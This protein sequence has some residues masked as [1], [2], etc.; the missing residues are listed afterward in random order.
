MA[1]LVR[2]ITS[3]VGIS[4]DQARQAVQT[5]LEFAKGRLPAPLAAQLETALND[6]TTSN[7]MNEAS[8]QLGTLGGMFG[9]KND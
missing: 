7:F 2:Q 3:R 1:E 8:K 4:E 9:G 6:G 5:V